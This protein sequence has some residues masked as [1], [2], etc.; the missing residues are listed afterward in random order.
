MGV[1]STLAGW[2]GTMLPLAADLH[3]FNPA[4]P[5]VVFTLALVVVL[6]I[7]L[8]FERMRLPGLIGLIVAGIILGP[9][10][11]NLIPDD[12]VV[13]HLGGAGLLYLMFL[14]G[15]EIDMHRFRQERRFSLVFG[16][17][18]FLIPQ[19]LGTLG[20]VYLLGL[21]WPAAILMA[22]MFASH[23]LVPYPIVQRLGLVKER[24][25]TTTAGGT[26]LTDTLALLV[27]AVVAESTRSGGLTG[28]FW[29]RQGLLFV[30]YAGAIVLS[31]P[32][33]SRWF[34]SHIGN[35]EGLPGFLFV[36]SFAFGC[37]VL[38]PFAGLE[39]I[40]GTFLAGLSLNLLIPEQSRLMIRLRF[41]GEALFIPFFLISVGL[42]VDVG[43]LAG[44]GKAWTVMLYMVA[45]G[46]LT[47][48]LAAVISGKMLQ[49][50]RNEIGILFGLSVNQAAA[51]LA[52]VIVGV[53]L[54]IFS[55]AILNGTILMILATCLLGPWVTERYGRRMAMEAADRRLE[56]SG[57]PE[58]IMIPV[59]DGK[60]IEPLMSLAMMIRQP[61][62]EERLYPAMMVPESD[63][64]DADA[65]AAEKLLATAT[66]QAVES[67][68]PVSPVVRL[69]V[70]L[71]DE[72]LGATRDLRIST[73]VL[74]DTLSFPGEFEHA[75]TRVIEHGRHQVFRFLNPAPLNT[76]QRVLAAVPPLMERQAGFPEAWDALL[77]LVSQA[78][79]AL[80]VMAEAPTLLALE[81]RRYLKPGESDLVRI[82]IRSA[83][84]V[85]VDFRDHAQPGD[86]CVL[87]SSRTGQLAWRPE[88]ARLPALMTRLL[89]AHPCLMIYPPE[90]KWE[91][92][93]AASARSPVAQFQSLFPEAQVFLNMEAASVSAAAGCIIERL[94]GQSR[95]VAARLQRD[96]EMMA[97]EAALRIAPDCLLLHSHKAAPPAPMVIL[98]TRAAGFAENH[99]ADAAQP[100]PRVLI[101]LLGVPEE[102]P[103]EHL[104]RL[105][106]I[107]SMFHVKGWLDAVCEAQGYDTLLTALSAMESRNQTGTTD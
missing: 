49:F 20:A 12:S 30:L 86:L 66:L 79:A 64:P 41:V 97:A 62:S 70:N 54:G 11:A 44:S 14:V 74:D 71:V 40:I 60:Q 94:F 15:L 75:P 32:R 65:A 91:Q 1:M 102:S 77:R 80:H 72:L 27:L 69:G 96:L 106:S 36:L 25:V 89:P 21:P 13:Q 9:H 83:G 28:M 7:P 3:G 45:A 5:T 95:A 43:L 53:E 98:A 90:M 47:K 46:Y 48:F 24:V 42:R 34:F 2:Q 57:A 56:S 4:D 78:G 37:A 18:T 92:D 50:S 104:R 100:Q 105:A 63:N 29:I 103:E 35:V 59:S 8:L 68:V 6:V 67:E 82:P 31:A 16:L 99:P 61:R 85:V 19:I 58:R 51:T 52:A 76:C 73:L 38:A 101:L 17:W 23:T 22:S 39:P 84:R 10:A 55:E 87:F 26:V 93:H 107:S 81:R 33:L 88:F